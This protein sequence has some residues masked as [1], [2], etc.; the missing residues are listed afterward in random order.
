MHDVGWGWTVLMTVTMVLFWAAVIY[1][2]VW[3]ARTGGGQGSGQREQSESAEDVLK[4]RLAGGEITV[5][6]YERIRRTLGDEPPADEDRSP[7]ARH[8]AAAR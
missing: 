8:Q 6:E 3:L 2:V 1:G 5:E 7:D 4:R